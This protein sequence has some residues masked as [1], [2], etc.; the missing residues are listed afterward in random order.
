MSKIKNKIKACKNNE[1]IVKYLFFLIS[2]YYY[3]FCRQI[4]NFYYKTLY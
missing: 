2:Y 4:L 1:F 3:F